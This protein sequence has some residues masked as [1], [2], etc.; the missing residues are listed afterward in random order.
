[1]VKNHL[2]RVN[3]PKTWKIERKATKYIIRPNPGG[4][5]LGGMMPLGTIFKEMLHYADTS[6]E[7]QHMLSSSEV[8]VDGRRQLDFRYGVGL[9]D[10][11]TFTK[12]DEHFRM[13]LNSEG[14]LYLLKVPK[15]E[16]SLTLCRI[17]G[18]T[19]L[20]TGIIQLN[21]SGGRS[22]RLKENAYK[23]GDS[24]L[25]EV[26][27]QAVRAHFPFEEGAAVYLTGGSHV[28]AFGVLSEVKGKLA[29][30]SPIGKEGEKFVTSKDY[31]FVVGKGKPAL[32]LGA[33]QEVS[34]Q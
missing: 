24:L 14:S 5:P 30:L 1:M 31:A 12:L 15:E 27:G 9:M 29:Y 4:Q 34:A 7:V 33:S 22:I 23:V 26:P 11:L 3:A 13:L 19:V 25:L 18:K 20:K 8:L 28:G 6:R 17:I 32:S 16:S 10:V 2:K 21:L